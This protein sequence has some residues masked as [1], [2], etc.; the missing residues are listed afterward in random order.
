MIWNKFGL[1]LDEWQ[2]LLEINIHTDG[3]L[4]GDGFAIWMLDEQD[5]DR[6]PSNE[7]DRHNPEIADNPILGSFYGVRS[8]FNGTA[9]V[10]DTFD[11][12]NNGDN[13][14]VFTVTN[15]G[16][17]RSWD[18]LK[19]MEPDRDAM[20]EEVEKTMIPPMRADL[21]PTECTLKYEQEDNVK[22]L[23]RYQDGKMHVYTDVEHAAVKKRKT[24]HER[25][26]TRGVPLGHPG[27]ALGGL[28]QKM[29]IC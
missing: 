18:M 9:I 16:T 12:N 20:R 7:A 8:D 24:M 10:F 13:P 21:F 5:I 28:F 19:D 23:I 22:I 26:K 2:I 6:P 14:V 17:A 3:K 25:I 27:F 11:N 1:H 29:G 4:G 15:D